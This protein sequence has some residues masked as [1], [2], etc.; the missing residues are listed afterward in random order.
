MTRKHQLIGYFYEVPGGCVLTTCPGPAPV[1]SCICG[2]QDSHLLKVGQGVKV[3]TL[4]TPWW[5]SDEYFT[6]QYRGMGLIPGWI[7]RYHVLR[8]QK[9][10]SIKQKQYCNKFHKNFKN[11]PGKKK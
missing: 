7:L 9:N 6:F 11:H 3:V 5:S 4:G 1:P 8:S 2:T 10:Q